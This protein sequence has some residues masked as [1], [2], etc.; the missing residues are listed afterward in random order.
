MN[1]LPR[2]DWRYWLVLTVA[3]VFGT[4]TG[5]FV[6]DYLQIGHLIG[7][8]WLVGLLALIVLADTYLKLRAPVWFW[9]AIITVRTAA[10][11]IGDGFH[12][13]HLGFG[14]S[15]PL[16]SVLFIGCVALYVLRGGGV[17]A[18]GTP[19]VD[20]AY[21]L[22]MALAG[23]WGTIAGDFVAFGTGDPP[24]MPPLATVLTAVPLALL[25]VAGRGGRLL[26]PVLYWL[27]IGIIRTTGTCAGDALNG[28]VG[29]NVVLA[30]ALSGSV[31]VGLVVWLYMPGDTPNPHAAT[32]AQT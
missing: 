32:E 6:S 4:N 31:F 18:D 25:F 24:L 17:R 12:D 20:W 2:V 22:C 7:L 3:S 19:K 5:D 26:T 16:V 1:S 29:G 30:S 27:T 8:P 9:A 21:W 10:T 13:Y 15:L 11:N 23:A 28:A 14:I